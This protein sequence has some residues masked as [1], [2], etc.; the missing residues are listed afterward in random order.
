MIEWV[1]RSLRNYVK[2]V[3]KVNNELVENK[4]LAIFYWQ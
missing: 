2:K 3:E 4:F 1:M